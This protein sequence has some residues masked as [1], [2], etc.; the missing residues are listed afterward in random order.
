MNKKVKVA[1]L[2]IISNTSLIVIK[3]AAGLISGS[4]SVIS[5]AI[6]S[7]MDLLAAIIAFFSVKISDTPADKTHPYGHGKF[8]NVSGVI[9]AIL[10][11]IAAVWIIVE[12]IEKLLHPKPIDS[13]ELGFLVMFVSAAI[14]VYVSGRLY[15]VA[16]ETESVALEADALHLKTDV[17]TSLG[18]G[19]GLLLIWIGK[20]IWKDVNLNFLDPI[21]AILVALFILRESFTLLRNAYYPLLDTAMSDDEIKIIYDALEVRSLHYHGLKTRKAGHYRFADLHLE[22]PSSLS[23]KDVHDVCD[24]IETELQDK[25]KNLDINIHVEPLEADSKK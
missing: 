19:C 10:I 23:L 11:F 6:H 20:F 17:Y 15:K 22:M 1:R 16:R 24:A 12:A 13:F 18:V 5:E 14:N 3:L 8:E 7:S 21:V 4:V 2:S 25:I 9:E